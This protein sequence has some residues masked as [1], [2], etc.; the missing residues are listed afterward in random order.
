[1]TREIKCIY[2]KGIGKLKIRE[3]K[4]SRGNINCNTEG[5]WWG[6]VLLQI[7]VIV[8]IPFAIHNIYSYVKEKS[9]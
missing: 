2:C 5:E 7:L 4:I 9:K 3:Y 8:T 1:M 6:V